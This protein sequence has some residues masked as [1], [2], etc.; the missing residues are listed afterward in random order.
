MSLLSSVKHIVQSIVGNVVR[1]YSINIS[2]MKEYRYINQWIVRYLSNG[3][4][5]N[6]IT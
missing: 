1:N 2:W 3:K 6:V 4:K 5:L